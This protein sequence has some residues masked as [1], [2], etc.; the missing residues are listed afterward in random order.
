[1][2]LSI[3][4]VHTF[5]PIA[6]FRQECCKHNDLI[7]ILTLLYTHSGINLSSSK[8]VNHQNFSKHICKPSFSEEGVI[9]RH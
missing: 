7:K 1:M 5:N 9:T 4:A 8:A 3:C 6:G 2:Q